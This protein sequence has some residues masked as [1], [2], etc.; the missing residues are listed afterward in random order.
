MVAG[1]ISK[2]IPVTG[3]EKLRVIAHQG[4]RLGARRQTDQKNRWALARAPHEQELRGDMPLAKTGLVTDIVSGASALSGCGLPSS[5]HPP[6][7][8]LVSSAGCTDLPRATAPGARCPHPCPCLSPRP[9][10][11]G[12]SALSILRSDA[13]DPRPGPAAPSPSGGMSEHDLV[14]GRH[15]RTPG[16][17]ARSLFR[18]PGGLPRLSPRQLQRRPRPVSHPDEFGEAVGQRPRPQQRAPSWGPAAE[19]AAA[20][21]RPGARARGPDPRTGRAAGIR[22]A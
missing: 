2:T 22:S 17:A 5:P 16:P 15:G 20:P 12:A 8:L 9:R 6:S 7:R 4:E 13:D 11:G 14:P 1:L 21:A 18:R 19:D 3:G 10:L